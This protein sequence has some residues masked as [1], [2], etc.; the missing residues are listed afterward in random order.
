M[1]NRL[2]ILVGLWNGEAL[3]AHQFPQE[4]GASRPALTHAELTQTLAAGD[5]ILVGVTFR[6][7]A[8]EHFLGVFGPAAWIPVEETP[9]PAGERDLDASLLIV[10]DSGSLRRWLFEQMRSGRLRLA[11]ADTDPVRCGGQ[12]A[13]VMIAPRSRERAVVVASERVYSLYD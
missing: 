6:C 11:R 10:D 13:L 3:D 5:Q 2:D 7:D 8:T 12:Q 4:P 9:L 1:D